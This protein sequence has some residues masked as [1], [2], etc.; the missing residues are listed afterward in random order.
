MQLEKSRSSKELLHNV[1][2]NKFLRSKCFLIV[3]FRNNTI[4]RGKQLNFLEWY[5]FTKCKIPLSG[6][7]WRDSLYVL[8][9]G[10]GRN[11]IEWHFC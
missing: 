4:Q 3:T 2:S 5:G 8:K 11:G 10:M 6:G 1:E 9:P 7:M